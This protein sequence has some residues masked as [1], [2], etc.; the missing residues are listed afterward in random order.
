MQIRDVARS[1][2][3]GITVALT[4]YVFKYLP[5]S[6][7]IILPIQV[8]IGISVFWLVCYVAKNEEY[9][10]IKNILTLSLEKFHLYNSANNGKS[11]D[12]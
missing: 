5:I 2:G 11:I 9:K 10:E 4:V 3:V 12:N 7:W 1:Y 6:S 8:V